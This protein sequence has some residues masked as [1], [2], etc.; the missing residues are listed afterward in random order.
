MNESLN[1]WHDYYLNFLRDVVTM[2]DESHSILFHVVCYS[3]PLHSLK[4]LLSSLVM[5]LG[6]FRDTFWA[7][8]WSDLKSSAR[9]AFILKLKET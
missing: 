9:N 4:G 8:H 7:L 5:R 3:L 1:C 6:I 2:L